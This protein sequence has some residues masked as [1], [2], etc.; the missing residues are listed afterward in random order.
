M[1]LHAPEQLMILKMLMDMLL[2][3]LLGLRRRSGTLLLG[4]ELEFTGFALV[5][6]MRNVFGCTRYNINR[7]SGIVQTFHVTYNHVN[8]IGKNA[9]IA[10]CNCKCWVK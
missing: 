3:V 10:L 7:R 8:S 5:S 4:G 6:H 2:E 1:L 9:H